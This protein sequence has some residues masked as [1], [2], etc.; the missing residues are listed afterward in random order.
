MNRIY[1]ILFLLLLISCSSDSE[2]SSE[3]VSEDNEAS[4]TTELVEDE[5][6]APA[7][8]L[9]KREVIQEKLTANIPVD[10]VYEPTNVELNLPGMEEYIMNKYAH[11]DSKSLV[12]VFQYTRNADD[13]P[14]INTQYEQ[15]VDALEYDLSIERNIEKVKINEVEWLKDASLSSMEIRSFSYIY[16]K[17]K[18]Q[19]TIVMECDN[20]EYNKW[21]ETIKATAESFEVKF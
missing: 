18:E 2:G 16:V 21:S 8:E 11:P 17:G 15:R 14:D 10:M 7:V 5:Q 20:D 3:N 9:E 19:I 12:F 1:Q 13:V 6:I 4:E